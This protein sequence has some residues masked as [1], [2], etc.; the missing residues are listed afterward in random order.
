MSIYYRTR[1][2]PRDF[3]AMTGLDTDEFDGLIPAFDDAW[4]TCMETTTMDGNRRW[5]R[6]YASYRNC[7]FPSSAEKLFFILVYLKQDARQHRIDPSG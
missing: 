3:R 6:T 1:T 2:K 4:T 7:P 5:C